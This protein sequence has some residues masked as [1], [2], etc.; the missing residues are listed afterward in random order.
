ML[1]IVFKVCARY[2]G[3]A[4][5]RLQEAGVTHVMMA[6]LSTLSVIS[7]L[8][9]CVSSLAGEQQKV[10]AH[11]D[12]VY[13]VVNNEYAIVQTTIQRD[14]NEAGTIVTRTQLDAIGPK[15]PSSNVIDVALEVPT[16]PTTIETYDAARVVDKIGQCVGAIGTEMAQMAQKVAITPE[17]K[18][19]GMAAEASAMVGQMGV[20]GIAA[21]ADYAK[22]IAEEELDSLYGNQHY[23]ITLLELLPTRYYTIDEKTHM[24]EPTP[25]FWPE[26]NRYNEEVEKYL[27]VLKKYN[28]YA[29]LYQQ[30]YATLEAVDPAGDDQKQWKA[31]REYDTKTVQ[32]ALIAKNKQEKL[33]SQLLP[34]YRIA[35]MASPLL[36]GTKCGSF[37]SGPWELLVIYYVG[38]EQTNKISVNYCV[39]NPKKEQVF[40]LE[41]MQ[42]A[43]Q[44]LD[45]AQKEQLIKPGGVQILAKRNAS[46]AQA[47][48]EESGD[49]GADKTQVLNWTTRLV[50][51]GQGGDVAQLMLPFDLYSLRASV[52]SAVRKRRDDKMDRV[53][54]SLDSIIKRT[55]ESKLGETQSIFLPKKEEAKG[56]AKADTKES[57]K[58]SDAEAKSE[59]V[60]GTLHKTATGVKAVSGI[61]SDIRDIGK[62]IAGEEKEREE[63]EKETP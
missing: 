41:L 2:I 50:T 3:Q 34:P 23:R 25:R 18:A 62:V 7:M 46:F 37:G 52:A 1:S 40:A 22:L 48:D 59:G 24:I 12:H 44:R 32:P 51:H 61:V 8:I 11:I 20:S 31:L 26:L 47:V 45:A 38:A 53:L 36:P 56:E 15:R 17:D 9:L 19:A 55:K 43:L 14:A 21:I 58:K 42:N 54:S 29:S 30:W 4:S 49:Y 27:S 39:P 13:G 16:A 33:V 35:I 60:L 57:E 10:A 6:R 63:A 28:D 5:L